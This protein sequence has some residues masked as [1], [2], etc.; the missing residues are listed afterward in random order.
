MTFCRPPLLMLYGS[1]SSIFTGSW[2]NFR[3]FRKKCISKHILDCNQRYTIANTG[4]FQY[5]N[6]AFARKYII[7]PF[8]QIW[9]SRSLETLN[10]ILYKMW[11]VYNCKVWS[12]YVQ[13]FK[14]ICIYIKIHNLTF[15]L[16]LVVKVRKVL[17]I[18]LCILWPMRL[19]TFKSLPLII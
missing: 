12:C 5:P 4:F 1:I 7:W 3:H 8:S 6:G 9:R 2:S 14:R 17:P 10:S 19:Q 18:T 11:H 15:D 16:D 13:S